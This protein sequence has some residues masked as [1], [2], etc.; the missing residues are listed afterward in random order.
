[1][2]ST[3]A[4]GMPS[5]NPN[6]KPNST[7]RLSSRWP[8]SR[9]IRTTSAGFSRKWSIT[10]IFGSSSWSMWMPISVVTRPTTDGSC[11]CTRE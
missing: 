11:A 5:R 9:K 2:L 4:T 1:M 6:T 3:I 7:M 8:K 10:M